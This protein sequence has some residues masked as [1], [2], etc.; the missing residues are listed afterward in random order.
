MMADY[1]KRYEDR[2]QTATELMWFG[3]R[4]VCAEG[5]WAKFE[6]VGTDACYIPAYLISKSEARINLLTSRYMPVAREGVVCGY[7][8]NA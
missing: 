2:L 1:L 6:D 4:L 5:K 8:I 7:L 3:D